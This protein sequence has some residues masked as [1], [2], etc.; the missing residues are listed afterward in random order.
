[1]QYRGFLVANNFRLSNSF[2]PDFI[3]VIKA[4]EIIQ[5]SYNVLIDFDSDI[6]QTKSNVS[7]KDN[8]NLNPGK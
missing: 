5:K 2:I 4:V 7:K 3:E 1:M 8:S 6:T